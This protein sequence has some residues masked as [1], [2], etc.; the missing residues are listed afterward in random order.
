MTIK[1]S[2]DGHI[3]VKWM[4]SR[5]GGIAA[6]GE[7]RVCFRFNEANSQRCV[8]DLARTSQATPHVAGLAAL[9]HQAH[10][11]WSPHEIK[12][13]IMGRISGLLLE[14][15]PRSSRTK[16][17]DVVVGIDLTATRRVAGWRGRI[18]TFDLVIQRIHRRCAVRGRPNQRPSAPETLP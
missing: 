2:D 15:A 11:G 18:R 4:S 14:P 1:H 5:I 8:N 12:A 6:G 13:A 3:E 7:W 17:P 9:V 16:P 10:P